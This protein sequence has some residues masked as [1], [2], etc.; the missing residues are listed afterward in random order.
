V[1]YAG[2][3]PMGLTYER[4]MGDMPKVPFKKDVWPKFLRQN[5]LTV[6]GLSDLPA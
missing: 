5:A 3:W 2:Y 1:I 6:L 4:I